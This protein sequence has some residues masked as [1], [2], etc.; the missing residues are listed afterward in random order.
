[1]ALLTQGGVKH[2]LLTHGMQLSFELVILTTDSSGTVP[3]SRGFQYDLRLNNA[4]FSYANLYKAD[5]TQSKISGSTFYHVYFEAISA[6]KI[7]LRNTVF[8][9]TPISASRLEDSD[10]SRISLDASRVFG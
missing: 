5:F 1:M 8:Y 3:D 9:F 4:D 7:N 10:L 6:N 2:Q